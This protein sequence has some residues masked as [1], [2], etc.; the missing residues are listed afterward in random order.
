MDCERGLLAFDALAPCGQP[1]RRNDG[2][3]KNAV[4]EAI[5]K[6]HRNG[7]SL[8]RTN[9]EDRA[10][11]EAA[12][13]WHGSWTAALE[14]AGFPRP[15]REFYTPDEV[16]L[17]IIDLYERELPLKFQSHNDKKLCRSA[18]KHFGGWRPAV[19][20]LG[21]G[22]ELPRMWTNQKVIEAIIR[23]RAEG[24]DM[25]ATRFEDHGLFVAGKIRFG[26]WNKALVAAGIDAVLREQWNEEKVLIRIRQILHEIPIHR[27][28]YVD[29]KL[30]C[31]AE[32]RF[33][34]IRKAVEIAL[35]ETAPRKS[36]LVK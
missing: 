1:E 31:A 7:E 25:S 23:R 10:L 13:N 26:S 20:S 5:R 24:S 36:R 8:V 19:E 30:A 27:I 12:N 16:R 33:G 32:R 15:S 17:R 6:R 18:K 14:A 29:S 35:S 11:Y 4:V 2:W 21:L 28:R 34:S 22:S 3:S 9:R